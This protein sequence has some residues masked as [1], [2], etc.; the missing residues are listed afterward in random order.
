MPI[1]NVDDVN[2]L[3]LEVRRIVNGIGEKVEDVLCVDTDAGWVDAYERGEN[4]RVAIIGG[5]AAM[6]RLYGVFKVYDKRSGREHTL[7]PCSRNPCTC[8]C[9]PSIMNHE[10]PKHSLPLTND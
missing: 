8:P 7:P 9:P 4:G 5:R 10:C 3:Y 6:K 1:Y 2:S